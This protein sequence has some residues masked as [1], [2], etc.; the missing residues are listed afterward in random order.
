MPKTECIIAAAT[1]ASTSSASEPATKKAKLAKCSTMIAT[2]KVFY[3]LT[4]YNDLV[5]FYIKK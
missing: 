4:F 2:A 3:N 5:K 1:A